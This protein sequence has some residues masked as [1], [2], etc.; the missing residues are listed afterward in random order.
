MR[1]ALLTLFSTLGVACHDPCEERCAN[2]AEFYDACGAELDDAG[3]VLVCYDDEV[4]AFEDGSVDPT[5]ARACTDGRDYQ[6]SCMRVSQAR[7]RALRPKENQS[8]LQECSQRDDW[9]EAVEDLDC[10]DAIDA[11]SSARG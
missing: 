11:W 2:L 5:H 3:V 1:V 9:Y 4:E 7:G 8:R 6:R 10:D